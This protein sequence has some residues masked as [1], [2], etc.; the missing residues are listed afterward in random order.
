[1]ATLIIQDL[2]L[3][4][5]ERADAARFAELCNDETLAR[6]TSRVPFPYTLEDATN[7]VKRATSDID[8]GKEYRFAVC[9][10]KVIIA[11]T[12]VMR[13]GSAEFE[14]GYW[15]G[16]EARGQGVATKAAS[17]VSQYAFEAL[18]GAMINAGYFL[19]NPAS[20]RVLTKL[21]FIPTGEILKTHSLARDGEVETARL[22][23]TSSAFQP[24]V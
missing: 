5:I 3:R 13:T 11:C 20:G 12:G 6:N 16:Q 9:R 2:V 19:D 1:M 14:L 4:P 8:D 22:V 21:G 23:L 10:K 17:A 15:V 7:F 24:I 18:G